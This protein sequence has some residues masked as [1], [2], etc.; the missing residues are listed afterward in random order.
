M[1]TDPAI[2]AI[3]KKHGKSPAQMIIRWHLQQGL[4]I[5]PKSTHAERL[6]ANLEV[7]DFELNDAEMDQ[8][9][10]LD[11]GAKG[12]TGEDPATANFTF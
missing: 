1:L 11:K 9:L 12:R 4:I 2:G 3:A 5:I 8:I 6:K 10:R 7:F